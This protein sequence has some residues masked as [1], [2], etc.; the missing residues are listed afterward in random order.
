MLGSMVR[1]RVAKTLSED[2]YGQLRDAI[3]EGS[4]GPGT[5]LKMEALCSE[6]GVSRS[7]LREA[8]NRL[9]EQ[10]LVILQP[11]SGFRV[12][13]LSAEDLRDLTEARIHIECPALAKS[14][15]SGGLEWEQ[16]VVAAHHALVRT[17]RRL[18]ADDRARRNP[19]WIRAHA[20]FHEALISACP[21]RRLVD[22]AAGLRRS[23]EIYRQWSADVKEFGDR[24]ID[25]EHRDIFDATLARDPRAVDLLRE[26]IQRT[27]DRLLSLAAEE[28]VSASD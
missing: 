21:N 10:D 14:M 18:V 19:D 8:L 1:I 17:P 6:L 11:Q 12:V 7:V 20:A 15:K 26:H 13:E 3:L 22:I 25:R 28:V 16:Q 2:V 9:V 24:D 27:T 23:T 5:R 4:L